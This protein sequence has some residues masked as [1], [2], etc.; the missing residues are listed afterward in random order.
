ME[1]RLRARAGDRPRI[2]G[3]RSPRRANVVDGGSTASATTG[4]WDVSAG[5]ATGGTFTLAIDGVPATA[6]IAWNASAADIE[7]ALRWPA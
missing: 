5:S 6:P 1:H 3:P 4:T 2:D 7:T